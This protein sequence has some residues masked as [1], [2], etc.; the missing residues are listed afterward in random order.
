MY[1]LNDECSM[2]L[3]DQERDFLFGCFR[4][5]C[6]CRHNCCDCCVFC[7]DHLEY[8][9]PLLK[10]V[11]ELNEEEDESSKL[12]TINIIMEYVKSIEWKTMRL[13]SF[14]IHSHIYKVR[15]LVCQITKITKI[16]RKH[17]NRVTTIL[18]K[19]T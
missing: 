17:E 10:M 18:K 19:L 13:S 4:S 8:D 15:L 2:S 7:W 1:F 16:S 11:M 3:I 12:C 5:C 6:C 9:L 14:I